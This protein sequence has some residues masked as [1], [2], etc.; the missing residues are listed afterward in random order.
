MVGETPRMVAVK[1][2]RVQRIDG[3]TPYPAAQEKKLRRELIV[4]AKVRHENVVE[5]LGVVFG[6]GVLPSMVSPW[7]S[8]GSLSDY[9]SNHGAKDLS[10]RQHLLLDIASVHS[11]G[12]VHGDLH[13]G[14]VLVDE[15]GRACLTDF[16]LSLII[17]D[18]V[19]T[20]YLKS[21]VCGSLRYADPELVRQVYGDGRMVYPTKPSDIYSFGG[22]MLYVLCGKHPYEGIRETLITGSILSGRRPLSPLDD[23]RLSPGYRSLIQQCWNSQEN[24]RPSVEDILTSLQEMSES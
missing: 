20:S 22:L 23:E 7:F 3:D 16:G 5:L 2:V 1:S 19:G 24:T 21:G 14:N 13:S 11:E 12:V 4:W 9:L 8:N 6:F 18:F 15:N 17:Q 10:E